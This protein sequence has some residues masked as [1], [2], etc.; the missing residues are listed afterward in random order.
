[1]KGKAKTV[2][3]PSQ[4]GK[5]PTSEVF[6]TSKGITVK[7]VG[8]SQLWLDKLRTAVQFPEPPKYS[9]KT[10][11]G[12]E[13]WHEHDETT[14]ETPEDKQAWQEYQVAYATAEFKRN[15]MITKYILTQGIE[16]VIPEEGDW[17]D[18][19]SFLGIQQSKNPVE[20]KYDYIRTEVLG[21]A[22]DIAAVLTKVMRLTGVPEEALAEAQESFRDML[23]G[24]DS[25]QESP[26]Q[27][28]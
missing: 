15:E 3:I 13:E 20:R 11:A 16:V 19:M 8:V 21:T 27:E 1:M 5:L 14:L 12:D 2:R 4:N 7:V 17:A 23:E 24:E 10:V 6:T 26:S 25:A 9:V 18:M 28:E 22:E